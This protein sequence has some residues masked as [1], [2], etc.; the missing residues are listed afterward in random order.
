MNFL[1]IALIIGLLGTLGYSFYSIL[2]ILSWCL[3][4]RK[5]LLIIPLGIVLLGITIW[6]GFDKVFGFVPDVFGNQ[7]KENRVHASLFE[8]LPGIGSEFM[9]SLG[10]GAFL[11]MP[12]SMPHA[13]IE[14]NRQV[15]RMLDMAVTAIPEIESVVGNPAERK[16]RL[17]P[18]HLS[19]I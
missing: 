16:Q 9:P 10:E 13:G 3:Y 15:L 17:I 12:T 2:K 8:D 5:K 4:N 1:F 7:V 14:Q 18:P 6:L 19:P 11:L